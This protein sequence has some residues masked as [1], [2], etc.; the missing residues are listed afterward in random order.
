MHRFAYDAHAFKVGD[1]LSFAKLGTPIR[2]AAAAVVF[3][4]NHP[5]GDPQPSQQDIDVTLRLKQ[6]G[7]LVGIAALD[8]V[9]VGADASRA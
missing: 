2:E 3:I 8:H 1:G 6:T 5:S 4:H 9:I 7:N